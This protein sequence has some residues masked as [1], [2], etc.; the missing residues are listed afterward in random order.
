MRFEGKTAVVTGGARGIGR[1]IAV[2]L[3]KSGA[4]VVV[5]DISVPA[6][7]ASDPAGDVL[8]EIR[9][10]GRECMGIAAD[11]RE[12]A[13]AQ[14]LIDA[15]EQAFGAVDILVNNAGGMLADQATSW[16]SAISEQ[17]LDWMIAVNLKS[18]VFCCQ[19]AVRGMRSR[20]SGVIV[21]VGS[22]I[23]LMPAARD[24]RSTHYG[25]A[26]SGLL[27]YTRCL[28]AE[29]GPVGIR[30]NCVSP[31]LIAT[32]RVMASATER[33]IGTDDEIDLIPLRR[34]GRPEDIAGAALFLASDSS[35]Y[36]TGQCLSVCGGRIMTP[37]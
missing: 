10:M 1:A 29:L 18:A 14:R 17:D 28:A 8:S 33:R 32:P 26:K 23:A 13:A 4:N 20:G 37:S 7:D 9:E 25:I 31:G 6:P 16:A 21:N 12:Q 24:G 34:R 35:S 11:L 27:H 30:V 3:A 5:G 22:G 15:A 36:V 19:A 2:A